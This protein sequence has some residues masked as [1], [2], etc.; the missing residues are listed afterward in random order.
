MN[1]RH[2]GNMVAPAF[3]FAN[4]NHYPVT[5]K[6]LKDTTILRL[7]PDAMEQLFRLDS[8]IS[9]NM[10]SILSNI[11]AFQAK[12]IGILSMNLREKIIHLLHEEQ[13]KQSTNRLLMPSRQ[14]LAN[15]LGVQ[16][17]SVQRTLN[18]LQADGTFAAT[19][20][21]V[22]N[23]PFIMQLPNSDEYEDCYNVEG[24]VTFSAEE[25]TV[26]ATTDVEQEKGEGYVLLGSYEGIE[27]DNYIHA[28]NDEEYAVG[29]D[30]YM[31]GG[32]FVAG[33]RAIRPFEAYIYSASANRA[34]YL[35]IG[36]SDTG[37]EDLVADK[38]EVW[39][40]LQ[41]IRLSGRPT[42]RGV[43]IRNGKKVMVR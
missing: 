42:E 15:M 41:G 14:E 26:L 32:V 18:E 43:Y 39:H 8:R 31:P 35:R 17:Y 6:A 16:K 10:V 25:V 36:G 29:G 19:Q 13:Q 23:K 38:D 40:T 11:V 3:I 34:P 21:I 1:L 28:L 5:V 24:K 2:A 30:T 20:R 12:K 27:S 7:L 4:D 37:M 22:A 9:S 33:S